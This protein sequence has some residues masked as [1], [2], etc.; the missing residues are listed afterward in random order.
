MATSSVNWKRNTALFMGGQAITM[1]G[2]SLVHFALMWHIVLQTESGFMMTLVIAAGTIPMFLITPFAGVWADRFNKKLLINIADA[3]IAVATLAM[4]LLISAGVE[5]IGLLLILIMIRGFG[6]GI[7]EPTKHSVIP[8][9]VPGDY[10]TKVN[11]FQGS[12][13]NIVMFASPMLGGALLAIAPIQIILFIDIITATIGISVLLFFVK[14]PTPVKKEHKLN[15]KQHFVEI[16]EGFKYIRTQLYLKKAMIITVL[17]NILLPP[18]LVLTPLLVTRVWDDY[19]TNL[20]GV[21]SLTAE[22]RLAS[23][24]VLL[25]LGMVLGGLIIGWW[26]GFKNKN[27][28]FSLYTAL[29]GIGVIG[30]GI[31]GNFWLFLLCMGLVGIFMSMRGAPAMAMLQSNVEPANMGR[32]FS[33]LQMVG[34]ISMPIAM[35]VW[36]PL[37]DV[38]D[39]EWLL[40]GTGAFI[41]LLGIGIMFDKTMLA[42]G[43][44]KEKTTEQ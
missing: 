42:A 36:G 23:V 17:I 20:F 33:A 8:E 19:S 44:P 32:F 5:W 30:V 7:Q 18:V 29:L 35:F 27:H 10:L 39:I 43:L 4:F 22:H 6:Q 1:F 21:F 37:G 16:S 15:V 40:I 9:I 41:V 38:V 2:S 13:S 34:S 25:S 3:V 11:G 12:I 31:T 26:G 28:T 14:V 24:S